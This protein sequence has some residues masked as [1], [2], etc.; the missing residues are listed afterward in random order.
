MTFFLS[1][2]SLNYRRSIIP[3]LF[4]RLNHPVKVVRGRISDLLCR[5]GSDHPNWVIFPAVV[6]SIA[7]ETVKVGKL[8]EE[9]V[10]E[11]E[12]KDLEGH[13]KAVNEGQV[14]ADVEMLPENFN[15][16]QE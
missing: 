1:F 13:V 11:Q 10:L 2:S 12:G 3:Q 5:I 14:E 6:G 16:Y 7:S 9:E 8:F 15:N 4:S